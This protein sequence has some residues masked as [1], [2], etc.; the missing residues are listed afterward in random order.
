MTDAVAKNLAEGRRSGYKMQAYPGERPA[1]R[2]AAFSLQGQVTDHL[3]WRP[4]GWKVGCTSEQAQKSLKTDRPF[5]GPIYQ[6][7]NFASGG[8]VMTM[9]DNWRVIEP[10][11]MFRMGRRLEPRPVAYTLDEVLAAVESVHGAI[12]VVNPRLPRGFDDAVEWYIADGA[13]ND[14]IVIGPAVRPMERADYARISAHA[15]RNGE[16]A[17]SGTGANALGGPELVLAWLVN[18]LS[19]MGT[20]LDAGSYVSTGVITG[21]FRAERGDAVTAEFT[22]L[23]TVGASF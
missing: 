17:G 16:K 11:I 22:T 6:E 23:G 1:T 14:A 18:E 2:S 19:S 21:L 7:R 10:E 9:P 8:Y 3:G 13:L 15:V 20:P 5:A 4:I 12:E